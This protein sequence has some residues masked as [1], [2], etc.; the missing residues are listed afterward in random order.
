MWL[1]IDKENVESMVKAKDPDMLYECTRLIRRGI[2]VYYN[3][4]KRDMMSSPLLQVWFNRTKGT[5]VNNR[6]K[7]SETSD[8]RKPRRPLNSSDFGPDGEANV[9]AIFLLKDENDCQRVESHNCVFIGNVGKEYA[10]LQKFINI[11]DPHQ[12]QANKI[13]SWNNYLSMWCPK[14]PLTDIV[15]ADPYY[16]MRK[17]TYR[18][19]DNNII[20]SLASPVNDFPVSLVILTDSR[21]IDVNINLRDEVDNIRDILI[22][23]TNNQ[24]CKVTIVVESNKIHDRNIITN[25]IQIKSGSGFQLKD[26]GTKDDV[27]VQILSRASLGNEQAID[28]LLNSYQI[29]CV[30]KATRG[31][32]GFYCIGDLIS[33]F[34]DF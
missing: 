24:N 16:F 3:F 27:S 32:S 10:I 29:D 33:N 20:R 13:K 12:E 5:G 34:L 15:L 9:E 21:Y 30:D 8:T 31:Y 7:Y 25:Y 4:P 26:N 28:N 6:T 2:D 1:Y 17:N 18:V 23:S 19:N 11:E 22:N 14:F